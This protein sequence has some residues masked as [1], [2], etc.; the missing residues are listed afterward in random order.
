MTAIK[1]LERQFLDL[2]GGHVDLWGFEANFVGF[3]HVE[4]VVFLSI[5]IDK[6][7]H[8]LLNALFILPRLQHA[9]TAL[10]ANCH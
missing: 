8:S 3:W 1:I 4:K 9:G 7:V 6:L 10:P 5:G 2:L